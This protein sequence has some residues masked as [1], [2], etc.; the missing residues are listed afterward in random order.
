MTKF[1]NSPEQLKVI[2][3]AMGYKINIDV[4]QSVVGVKPVASIFRDAQGKSLLNTGKNLNFNPLTNP[5]QLNEIIK[6]IYD[7]CMEH[8]ISDKM[9]AG[10]EF[11]EAIMQAAWEV[12]SE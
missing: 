5:A 4:E 9:V 6:W 7:K 12:V 2:A 1:N 8:L 10:M 3:E 11:K